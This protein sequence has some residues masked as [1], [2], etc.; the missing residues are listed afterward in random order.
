MN[1]A[2][3]SLGDLVQHVTVTAVALGALGVV[4]RRVLGVFETRPSAAGRPSGSAAT[5]ACS[6]CAAG[7]AA[8]KKHTRR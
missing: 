5:P 8:A 7:S 4:L 6:H 2:A 3:A 1:P